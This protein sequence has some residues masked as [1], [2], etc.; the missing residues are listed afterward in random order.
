MYIHAFQTHETTSSPVYEITKRMETKQ[1]C[2]LVL[3]RP[4]GFEPRT[5]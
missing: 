3:V 2:V 4:Q 1:K 5:H